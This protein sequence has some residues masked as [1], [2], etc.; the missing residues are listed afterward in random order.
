M[1]WEKLQNPTDAKMKWSDCVVRMKST[2][3]MVS[4]RA[5]RE[6]DQVCGIIIDGDVCRWGNQ[7][8]VRKC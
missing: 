2:E 1:A 5:G 8:I 7:I 4:T 6:D 3:S